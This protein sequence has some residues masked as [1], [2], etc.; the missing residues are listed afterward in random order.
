MSLLLESNIETLYELVCSKN[1]VKKIFM[2]KDKEG[3]KK[4]E[5]GK[6]IVFDRVYNINELENYKDIQISSD[7][8]EMLEKNLG[9]I[10]VIFSTTHEIIKK[11]EDSFIVKYT[12]ILKSPE[13][14]YTIVGKAKLILYVQF[15]KNKNDSEKIKVVWNKRF[16]NVNSEDNDE[17]ILNK[18][19]M[20]IINNIYEEEKLIINESIIKL[21][22]SIVGKEMI[23][24]C[25][26]P[27]INKLFSDALNVIQ[28]I[29]VDG[30]V[31]FFT[32]KGIKVFK[33]K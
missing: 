27:Y 25:V 10:D 11:D 32:K 8:T 7:I 22:E 5:G 23:H 33:K 4:Y 31:D 29:Y 15:S 9:H 18:G 28:N 13:L 12:S 24:E 30:G 14:I 16:L 19:S 17:L 26:I 3:I 6:R 2:L 20:D 1:F 21:S